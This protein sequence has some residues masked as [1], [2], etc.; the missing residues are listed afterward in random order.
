MSDSTPTSIGPEGAEAAGHLAGDRARRVGR[1]PRRAAAAAEARH[2]RGAAPRVAVVGLADPLRRRARCLL[3]VFSQQRL[4]PARRLRHR[5]L[6]AARARPERRRRLGR[7]ARP[8]LRRLLR[9]RRV[10]VRAAR[11]RPLRHPP[12]DR[13]S[14]IPIVV[15]IGAV[16]RLPGRPAVATAVRR[17]PGDRHALLPPALPDADD[18]RRPV[19]VRRRQRHRRRERDP[20]RRPARP[21]RPRARR[22]ARGR[23]RRRLLLRRARLLRGRLRRCSASSTTRARGARGARCA[24]TRSPPR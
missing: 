1:A 11:L 3:P 8:R 12:A 21:L 14:S 17:L 24:R 5:A 7:A 19:P 23:V 13:S 20:A 16:G 22:P 4:R 2:G 10:R 9:H 6:H 18:E 15:T